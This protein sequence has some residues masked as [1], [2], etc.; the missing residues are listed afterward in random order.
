MGDPDQFV[1]SLPEV[2]AEQ[3]GDAV[4]RHYIVHMR[5]SGHH[6]ATWWENTINLSYSA[7]ALQ[8]SFT[9]S[10]SRNKSQLILMLVIFL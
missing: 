5:A 2:L 1:H 3:V 7:T 4:F 8:G 6:T 10:G 9:P